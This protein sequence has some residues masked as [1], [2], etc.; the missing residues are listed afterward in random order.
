MSEKESANRLR[1]SMENPPTSFGSGG[2]D[3]RSSGS[4]RPFSAAT[5]HSRAGTSAQGRSA[6]GRTASAKPKAA[7]PPKGPAPTKKRAT[8]QLEDQDIPKPRR[9]LGP[10]PQDP[11][12]EAPYKPDS[13]RNY[14]ELMRFIDMYSKKLLI[15]TSKN[16][17]QIDIDFREFKEMVF[18]YTQHPLSPEKMKG[19]IAKLRWTEG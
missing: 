15:N 5:M 6:G 8:P 11:P 9:Y 2:P 7:E 3:V 10:P 1:Q 14:Q 4:S 12:F 13:P 19:H 16:Q 17:T 18:D